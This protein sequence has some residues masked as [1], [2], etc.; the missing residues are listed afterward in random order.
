MLSSAPKPSVRAE[1]AP[2]SLEGLDGY[3][4]GY[5][6]PASFG[7]CIH[8]MRLLLLPAWGT[9]MLGFARQGRNQICSFLKNTFWSSMGVGSFLGKGRYLRKKTFWA[10]GRILL[11]GTGYVLVWLSRCV[12]RWRGPIA[13]LWG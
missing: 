7:L 10:E 12:R 1:G 4:R 9:P 6:N 5:D 11:T 3:V 2:L 13:Q 8:D